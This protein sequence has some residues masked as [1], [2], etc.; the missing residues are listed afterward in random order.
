[1]IEDFKAI[2]YKGLHDLH[3]GPLQ[4]VNLI[5]GPNGVGKTSL[6]EALGLFH[7]RNKPT[8][9]WGL[10]RTANVP[11]N[12]LRGLG[13]D[14]RL[15]GHEDEADHVVEFEY[16]DLQDANTVEVTQTLGTGRPDDAFPSSQEINVL[17][18]T[19][20][21][22]VRYYIDSEETVYESNVS[23]GAMGPTLLSHNAPPGPPRVAAF[24][25]RND[26]FPITPDVIDLF[27]RM[28]AG[29]KKQEL[30]DLLQLMQ[31]RVRGIEILAQ[32]GVPSLWADTGAAG[33]LPVED[34]GG[35][36]VRL[37]GFLVKFFAVKG[38]LVV[39]D[40]IENG[41]HHSVLPDLWKQIRELSKAL[42]VQVVA[43]THSFECIQA[44]VMTDSEDSLPSDF[45]VHRM[46]LKG[47][48]PHCITYENETLMAS[49]DLGFDVR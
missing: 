38:G 39:I 31:P 46:Y 33:L 9:L 44:A 36:V 28:I 17:P 47:G 1:M 41:I 10:H 6:A 13:G 49:L 42:D 30:L 11:S 23:L 43:T 40:E 14:V 24:M 19:G 20:R 37:L 15:R 18:V 12:P 21:L 27:S 8:L 32:Q 7:G 29:G 16:I 48:A 2:R 5:T 35:G 25:I 26:P 4:R 3:V 22:K 34:L 45:A